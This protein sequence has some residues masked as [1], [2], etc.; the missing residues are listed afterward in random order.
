MKPG[1]NKQIEGRQRSS[2]WPHGRCAVACL[3]VVLL[4]GWAYVGAGII[5]L[6][7]KGQAAKG[8]DFKVIVDGNEFSDPNHASGDL[9]QTI[10]GRIQASI[11]A[12]P[13]YIAEVVD[14]NDPVRNAIRVL[15]EP[16]RN[17]VQRLLVYEND[18]NIAGG[19]AEAESGGKPALRFVLYGVDS[20]KHDGSVT[21]TV[22][23]TSGSSSTYVVTTAGK[24]PNQVN[25]ELGLKLQID[26]FV[27]AGSPN[28][29]WNVVKPSDSIA[30]VTFS[31]TDTGVNVSGVGFDFTA[32][33]HVVPAL[34]GFGMVVLASLLAAAAYLILR[35]R[36][37]GAVA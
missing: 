3:L 13:R 21:L 16:S 19:V 32:Q 15:R 27:V 22:L 12:D 6:G 18:P 34:S 37:S 35:R 33:G 25:A 11:N 2:P 30:K 8:S 14:P 26:G 17:D 29:P 10:L 28:G 20:V 23:L 5:E 7:K 9:A 24:D 36:R 31:H 1:A 4:T